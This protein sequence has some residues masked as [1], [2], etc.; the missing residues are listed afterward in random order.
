MTIFPWIMGA[1]FCSSSL[2][3]TLDCERATAQKKKNLASGSAKKEDLKRERVKNN[4]MLVGL[5]KS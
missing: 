5:E 1:S 4:A 3:Y 2:S